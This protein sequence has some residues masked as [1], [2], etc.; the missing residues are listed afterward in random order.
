M[1]RHDPLLTVAIQAGGE[2]RRM[3]VDKGQVDFRG[4]P[5]IARVLERLAPLADEFLVTTNHP[6]D[7]AFLKVHCLPD[8]LPGYGALGGLYTALGAA[9][10]A[11]VA[12]VA[13]DMPFANADLLVYQ[14]EEILAAAAD[15][16]I[17][18]TP[19]GLEP[20]HAVYRKATCLPLVKSALE[21]GQRRVDSWFAQAKIRYLTPEEIARHDPRGLAFLNVN[22][23]H[24]L[25]AAIQLA[26]EIS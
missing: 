19:Q 11:L 1:N 18:R 25:A 21:A 10:H 5:L 26:E 2:S 12:V 20:F 9:R 23:P 8:V 6:E 22:T 16:V 14:R 4:Q 13:C 3:G 17:P 15:A 7:Y 24:E